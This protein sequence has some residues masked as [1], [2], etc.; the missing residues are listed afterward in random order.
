MDHT[1]T[2][3]PRNAI[4]HNCGKRW[5]GLSR[6]HCPACHETFNSESAADKHRKGSVVDGN[7]RCIPPTEAGLVAVQQPWGLCWQTPGSDARFGGAA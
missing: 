1:M 6:S 2:G 5:T 3:I 7:R 4:F